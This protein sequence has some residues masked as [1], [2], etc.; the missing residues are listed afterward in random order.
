MVDML[1]GR[2][3]FLF[4][5]WFDLFYSTILS[6][7]LQ[8]ILTSFENNIVLSEPFSLS[9]PRRTCGKG[10]QRGTLVSLL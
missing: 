10:Y 1:R 7:V 6:V 8:R 2:F 4:V 3:I 9:K 5:L